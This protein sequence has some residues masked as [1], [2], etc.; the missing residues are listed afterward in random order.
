MNSP[1]Y[2]IGRSPDCDLVINNNF[3]SRWHAELVED[4]SGE[5]WIRDRGSSNG[6]GL[7]SMSRRIT[8]SPLREMDLVFFS[9]EYP[10]PGGV[11]MGHLAEW[12]ARGGKGRA[13]GGG[14]G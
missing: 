3:V 13:S 10:V 8:E 12:R 14:G 7:G 9:E 1:P 11:L 6:T 5:I 2:V 4:N